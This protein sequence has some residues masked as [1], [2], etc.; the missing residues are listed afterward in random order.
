[1]KKLTTTAIASLGLSLLPASAD[2]L[3]L[4]I[5]LPLVAYNND[6][7]TTYD[8]SAD[9][10]SVEATPLFIIETA[11]PAFVLPSPEGQDISI[12]IQVDETGALVDGVSGDDFILTGAVDL[13]GDTTIDF[14][15]VLLTGE[16]IEFGFENSASTT[17]LYDFRFEVTGGL[18]A[19]L[20]D[21]KDIVVEVTSEQS[22]FEGDFTVSFSGEAK[23]NIGSTDPIPEVQCVEA[24]QKLNGNPGHAFW[25]P[26]IG[27]D[28]VFDPEPG[29]FIQNADGTASITGEIRRRSDPAIAFSVVVDLSGFTAVAPS[30]SPKKELPDS[31][32]VENGGPIDTSTWVYYENVMGLLVGIDALVGAEVEFSRIGPAF[33]LGA[34]ANGKNLEFGASTWFEWTVISEADDPSIDLP[35]TG[36]GDINVNIFDCSEEECNTSISGNLFVDANRNRKLDD[37]ETML[38]NTVVTLVDDLGVEVA[39]TTDENG[40]YVFNSLVSGNYWVKVPETVE[41]NFTIRRAMRDLHIEECAERVV[42]FRYK[43]AK[44]VIFGRV[45]HD[46]NGNGV[47]DAHE[48]GIKN[49]AIDITDS[50]AVTQTETTGRRGRYRFRRIALGTYTVQA[51]ATVDRKVLTTPS[52][53][54]TELTL[55]NPRQRVVFGYQ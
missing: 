1:M 4:P 27:T 47:R 43:E 7:V 8:A 39:S 38:P 18:L 21:G 9:I 2:L 31:K 34:G 24:A 25:L 14:S 12:A 30:G 45:F 53:V 52:S 5:G 55:S 33:Q 32:Y 40:F 51:P 19:H 46:K 23:G 36:N 44:G 10:F 54:D 28:F 6:G 37:G 17:D 15:G 3:N 50:N 20:Y 41:P 42:N 13:E 35:D 26:G 22:T 16:I 49:V 29:S 11:T 48:K